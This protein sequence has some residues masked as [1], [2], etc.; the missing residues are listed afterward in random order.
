M[1]WHWLS[2]AAKADVPQEEAAAVLLLLL[3]LLLP[4]DEPRQ[5]L[6][7]RLVLFETRS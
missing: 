2:D 3:L 6:I 1:T 5:P 4:S 7:R